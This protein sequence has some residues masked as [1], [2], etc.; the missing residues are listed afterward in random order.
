MCGLGSE[1]KRNRVFVNLLIVFNS[2]VFIIPPRHLLIADDG[3]YPV[4]FLPQTNQ[5]HIHPVAIVRP[6]K[7]HTR[8]SPFPPPT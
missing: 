8:V 6:H 3:S 7:A 2:P 4:V 5:P 1:E